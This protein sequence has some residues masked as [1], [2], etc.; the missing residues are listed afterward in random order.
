[1]RIGFGYDIH[2][3]APNR[4]LILGGIHVPFHKGPAGHSD[5]DVLCHAIGDALLGAASLGDIGEHFPDSDPQFKNADSLVLL[6][7][8]LEKIS[9][10]GFVVRNVDATVVLE[11]PSLGPFKKAMVERVA[12]ALRLSRNEVSVK[13]KTNERFE[14]VGKGEAV[15]A[16]AVVL[17]EAS[18]ADGR[19]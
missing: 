12:N 3:L 9:A 6:G 11:V 8:I 4:P 13:A 17:L 18:G 14:A 2:P 5:A 7:R 10:A 16:F 15:A 19:P 1:V